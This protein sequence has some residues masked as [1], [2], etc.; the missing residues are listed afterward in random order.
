[1]KSINL[2]LLSLMAAVLIV[3]YSYGQEERRFQMYEVHEDQVKP[4]MVAQYEKTA[5]MFADKMREHEITDGAFLVTNTSD[6]RYL[7][8]N[9]IDSLGQ[10]NAGM[11]QLWEKMG[12]DAFG[13]MMS[14]FDPCYDR[15]GS[16]VI[17]MDK[18]LTYMPEGITQTPDGE[19]YRKFYYLYYSPQNS[20]KIHDAM[21]GIKELFESKN[22]KT[23][24]RVYRSGYGNMDSFYM[25][26]TAAKD[27][28]DMEQ[29][30]AA[31]DKL[32]G[33]DAQAVFSKVID[34]TLKMEEVSGWIR[35]ELGYT[36][37]KQD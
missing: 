10:N 24:Y 23:S 3:G 6:F 1:M 22:S 35:P 15:H 27:A 2:R 28:L 34:L 17:Y 8:V 18:E 13:E 12:A 31:N 20:S 4:S 14:G 16:Y 19:N 25:V 26:A 29:R 5:K 21:K 11:A 7:Y 30:G 36:P 9:P 37:S 32:L 33:E